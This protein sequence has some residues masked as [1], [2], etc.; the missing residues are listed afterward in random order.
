MKEKD[1]GEALLRGEHPV[2]ISELT[3]NV[4]KRDRRRIWIVATLCV[5]AWLF[6]VL[7][8]WS[9]ILPSLRMFRDATQSI[10][11]PPPGSTIS[12]EQRQQTLILARTIKGATI[13]TFSASVML[14]IAVVCTLALITVSRRATLRQLNAR[15]ADISDQLRAL[16]AKNP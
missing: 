4:L 8:P 12:P 7:L 6:V 3:R 5:F 16:A 11:N 15:L 9:T 10:V 1:L 13:A 2:E 14:L